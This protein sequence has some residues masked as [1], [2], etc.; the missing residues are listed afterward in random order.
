MRK[1]CSLTTWLLAAVACLPFANAEPEPMN[2]V[3][4]ISDDHRWDALGAAGNE[5]IHTPTL[6]KFAENGVKFTHAFVTTS[7]C[8]T[9]RASILTGQYLS[10]HG[11]DR[12]HKTISPDDFPNTYTGVLRD[13][14]YWS[15]FV[16]KYGIG[17]IRESDFDFAREYEK[18]HWFEIDGER[19]HVTERNVRDALE[20]L[21][22]RPT[23]RP[24]LLNVSYFAPH[25]EDR[26]KEQ[27]K[28][29]DWSAQFYEGVTIPESPLMDD[30]YLE[31]LPHF[32]RQESNFG[33]VRYRWRFDTPERYQEYM[34]NYFR[35]ITE[36]DETVERII[37]ELK[38]QGVYENT[39][40]IFMGDNGY[41]HAERGLADK[42][43]SYEE[44]IRVPLLIHDPRLPASERGIRR[45]EMV[46]NIDLAPTIVKAAGLEIPEVMQGEDLSRLY[47]EN[48]ASDWRDEFLY[49]HQTIQNR[50]RIPASQGVVRRD[51]KYT[52]WPEWEYEQLFDL[53]VD[54]TEKENRANDPAYATELE[55][56][57]E[58][59]EYWLEAAK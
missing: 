15:G 35:L 43:Y 55:K 56:M 50:N 6:D 29:Q 53:R 14:G 2:V 28:P 36:I 49:E 13:A 4:L 21:R 44:S 10:R 33:R 46:L 59:L 45:D 54:P 38:E 26:S 8:V 9:S 52:Y 1:S 47:L 20:F 16:G 31:A 3:V 30:A 58:R 40:I 22:E 12:F 19:I 27:Y 18:D 32:L 57:R 24:F 48:D 39:L 25:A 5:Q 34:T 37:N 23:D 11:I 51:L 41:F 17:A 42:W 7:I